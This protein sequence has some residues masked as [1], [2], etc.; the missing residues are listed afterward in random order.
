MEK[1]WWWL[2]LNLFLKINQESNLGTWRKK[3][4]EA[5][6]LVKKEQDEFWTL[7]HF[8]TVEAVVQNDNYQGRSKL[9]ELA[10]FLPLDM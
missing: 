9:S 2:Q 3:K 10:G 5:V 4:K 7:L 1:P 6:Y 8:S